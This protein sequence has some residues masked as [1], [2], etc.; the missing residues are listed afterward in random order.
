M[1]GVRATLKYYSWLILSLGLA[2]EML[3]SDLLGR[4]LELVWA[5]QS[6]SCCRF[7]SSRLS[8]LG[9]EMELLLETAHPVLFRDVIFLSS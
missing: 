5:L 3:S 7:V 8:E 9:A 1:L 6:P 4:R 2:A